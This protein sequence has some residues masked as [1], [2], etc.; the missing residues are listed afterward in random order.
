MT[1]FVKT[2]NDFMKAT[3]RRDYTLTVLLRKKAEAIKA[4]M[5]P[6]ELLKAESIE[7][8]LGAYY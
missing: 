1:E 5:N 2:V 8:V 7:R 3:T 4:T 6:Q